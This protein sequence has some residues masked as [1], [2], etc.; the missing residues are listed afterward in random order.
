MLVILSPGGSEKFDI[1]KP[2]NV[3]SSY[4]EMD[5]KKNMTVFH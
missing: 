3:I 1:P 5:L 4:L 2:L